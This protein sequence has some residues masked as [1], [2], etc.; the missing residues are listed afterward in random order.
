MCFP[1]F[2]GEDKLDENVCD[3]ENDDNG[4][5]DDV[6]VVTDVLLEGC[7]GFA[8]FPELAEV[9]DLDNVGVGV[10]EVAF[11]VAIFH[12]LMSC[13]GRKTSHSKIKGEI[14]VSC[15]IQYSICLTAPNAAAMGLFSIAAMREAEICDALRSNG[16][17]EDF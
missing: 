10:V 7:G 11:F 3:D 13:G 5:E 6:D 15:E 14:G 1:C 4:S 8:R 12:L 16:V 9:A 17:L 2:R